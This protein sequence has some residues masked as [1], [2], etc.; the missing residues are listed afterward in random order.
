MSFLL[1]EKYINYLSLNNKTFFKKLSSG[2]AISYVLNI[3]ALSQS[4]SFSFYFIFNDLGRR[5]IM[6][7]TEGRGYKADVTFHAFVFQ[8]APL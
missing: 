8:M 2:N 5:D 4:L 1:K 7:E 3:T 6:L